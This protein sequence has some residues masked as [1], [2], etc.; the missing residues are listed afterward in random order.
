MAGRIIAIGDVH[1]CSA[2]WD[3]VLAAVDPRPD[4]TLVTLGD[5]IDRGPDSRGVLDRLIALGE[6]RR[7]VPILGNH[8][9]MLLDIVSLRPSLLVDWLS[10]GGDATLASY[11]C[12]TPQGIPN[13]HIGFL[14][15]CVSWHESDGHFYVHASYLPRKP[16][17]QQPL[18]VLR[19]ESIR[20]KPPGPHRSGKV[21]V[22]SHTS[23]KTGEVLDLGHLICIDTWVYGD[24]WLTAMDVESGQL[25]QADKLGRI[26]EQ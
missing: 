20:R 26:R 9:E 15:K 19:W 16:L 23:Q 10:F 22:V 8:D 21:A 12:T 24:G 17:H 18:D 5:Y 11:G 2:A 14:R 3:A 4:D 25:W 6:R 1:G 13:E 7:L